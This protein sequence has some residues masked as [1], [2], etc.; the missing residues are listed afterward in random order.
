MANP[1]YTAQDVPTWA[2]NLDSMNSLKA[3]GNIK[4]PLVHLSLLND[5][6]FSCGIGSLTFARSTIG[7]Y[8]DR[9]GVLQTAAIDEPRFEANGLL[10]EGASTNLLDE[11]DDFT[12]G[13]WVLTG[14]MVRTGGQADPAGGTSAVLLDDTDTTSNQAY[15]Q[16]G[17]SATVA[18][19]ALTRN[20]SVF[21]KQ[22][23][24]AKTALSLFLTGGSQV[25]VVMTIDWSAKT[26]DAGT[27]TGPFSN[28]FYRLELP[29]TNNSSGNTALKVR[30]NPAG[31][32]SEGAAIGTVTAFRAQAEELPFATSP[33]A[34][35]GAPVTRTTESLLLTYTGNSSAE[36]FADETILADIEMLGTQTIAGW[37]IEG[38]AFYRLFFVNPNW[39]VQWGDAPNP[40]VTAGASAAGQMDRIGIVRELDG[41]V[42]GWLNGVE[43]GNGV[44][45]GT[46]VGTPTDIRIGDE[47]GT[48]PLYGHLTNFRI[49]DKALS[50]REMAVA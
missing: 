49:Y 26:V 16:D 11:S 28:G 32:T 24:A 50:D 17:A 12:A 8:I 5:L 30:I 13:V 22:G 3:I 41:T 43:G 10:I 29:I 1:D 34:T 14:T 18:N 23:T 38:I 48:S 35:A 45:D 42:T 47:G 39:I 9:Y 27:L 20:G 44:S 19:D 37:A 40:Q 31:G 7:S 2:A 4:N 15:I 6:S 46:L 33:I 25:S 36:V 21:L